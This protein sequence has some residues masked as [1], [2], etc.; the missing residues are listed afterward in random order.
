MRNLQMGLIQGSRNRFDMQLQQAG[1]LQ[2][3]RIEHKG[4]LYT[5]RPVIVF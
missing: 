3:D 4:S 2:S 1:L 5:Q